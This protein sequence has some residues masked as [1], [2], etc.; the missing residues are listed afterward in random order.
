MT[1]MMPPVHS[2]KNSHRVTGYEQQIQSPFVAANRGT[3]R[4]MISRP[5]PDEISLCTWLSGCN[6]P[7]VVQR[8]M[9]HCLQLAI[10]H[11]QVL[12]VCKCA[13]VYSI[14]TKR[15]RSTPEWSNLTWAIKLA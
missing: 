13:E 5:Y 8:T 2:F 7:A 12:L 1:Q 10:R 14:R 11:I 3:A 6:Q 4:V 9:V 15:R